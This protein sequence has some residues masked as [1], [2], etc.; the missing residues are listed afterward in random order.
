VLETN[1]Y[2]NMPLIGF[3]AQSG[4]PFPQADLESGHQQV[5]VAHL[6]HRDCLQLAI[7]SFGSILPDQYASTRIQ[8]HASKLVKHTQSGIDHHH[9]E[10]ILFSLRKKLE[11][12]QVVRYI[13]LL[14]VT[15]ASELINNRSLIAA[16][17]SMWYLPNFIALLAVAGD[18]KAWDFF[19]I[20]TVLLSA[21]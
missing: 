4:R 13:Q 20:A 18:M 11:V 12:T 7:V 17:Q 16:S 5:H 1:N 3:S 8:H 21:P 10:C 19:A 2:L 14:S 9:C 6:L 15:L